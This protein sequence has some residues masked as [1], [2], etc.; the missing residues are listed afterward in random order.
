MPQ[1]NRGTGKL[2]PLGARHPRYAEV[3][4]TI[5]AVLH[6]LTSGTPEANDTILDDLLAEDDDVQE[7]ALTILEKRLSSS[8]ADFPVAALDLLN[9]FEFADPFDAWD[10]IAAARG[11]SDVLRMGA[12]LR[13]GWPDDSIARKRVSFL[14]S[15]RGGDQALVEL[16]SQGCLGWPMQAELLDEAFSYLEAIPAARRQVV[17]TQIAAEV[18]P[19][20][21]LLLHAVLHMDDPP[22]QRVALQEVERFGQPVSIRSVERLASTSLDDSIREA[23]AAVAAVLRANPAREPL[24]PRVLPEVTMSAVTATTASG[25]QSVSVYRAWSPSIQVMTQLVTSAESGVIGS[26]GVSQILEGDIEIARA[27]HQRLGMEVVDVPIDVT[28]GV[29]LHGER[30]SVRHGRPIPPRF[31]LWEPLLHDTW[32]PAADEPVTI[33]LLDDADFRGERKLVRA[34]AALCDH[35]LFATWMFDDATTSVAMESVEP[36]RRGKWTNRQYEPLIRQVV[37]IPV[38]NTL[39]QSLQ[40]QAWLLDHLGEHQLRNTA[41]AVSASLVSA[42]SVELVEH[43]FLRRMMEETVATILLNQLPVINPLDLVSPFE[44]FDDDD[45]LE[46]GFDPGDVIDIEDRRR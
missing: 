3:E 4:Q 45:D 36:P 28:R 27:E 32:P 9:V 5:D 23:A 12:R 22:L 33:P 18:G 30:R 25:N 19:M 38:R 42:T 46:D 16:V 39:R 13:T 11:A 29:V 40:L 6:A 35:P 15:M 37:S 24:A 41:L 1:R 14:K 2:L 31:E 26:Y 10:R 21:L 43:P 34:S 8:R 44:D 20:S 17:V 7:L